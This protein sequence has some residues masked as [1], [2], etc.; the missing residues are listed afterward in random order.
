VGEKGDT[1]RTPEITADKSGTTTTIYA[2]GIAI[3]AIEDGHDAPG[4]DDLRASVDKLVSR[5]H[6]N[7]LIVINTM[8]DLGDKV[9]AFSQGMLILD[10]SISPSGKKA[11]CAYISY[12]D[13]EY[14]FYWAIE[15]TDMATG[16]RYI[17]WSKTYFDWE[18]WKEIA[19]INPGESLLQIDDTQ[20]SATN[21]WSGQKINTE[22]AKKIDDVTIEGNSIVN[23]GVA[24]IPQATRFVP[25]VIKMGG[26]TSGITLVNGGL[27]T[28]P[29]NS[30]Q[31]KDGYMTNVIISPAVQHES[32]FYGLAKAAGDSTQSSSSNA[33]GKYTDSAKS[34]IQS[35]LGVD[36]AIADAI[37]GVTQFDY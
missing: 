20:A 37:S 18:P 17:T 5:M 36:K 21:P 26:T 12:G 27:Y 29:A 10:S 8:R 2:D 28:V 15:I 16:K 24:N 19:V 1:G 6:Y 23:N 35:M 11:Y 22:L 3:G 9:D 4:T 13:G 14:G 7:R 33:V 30:M 32:M 25:G 34:A 31:I